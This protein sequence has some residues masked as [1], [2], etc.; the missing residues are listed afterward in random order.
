M[1]LVHI[2]TVQMEKFRACLRGRPSHPVPRGRAMT[3]LVM[4]L[5]NREPNGVVD[6]GRSMCHEASDALTALE[7]ENKRMRAA[8][9][10]YADKS[11]WTR[12][13]LVPK[14]PCQAVYDSGERARAAL[15]GE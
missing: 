1:S 8:L 3:D 15:E 6:H 11:N 13:R 2:V 4:R 5:R 7:E 12:H 10:W 14:M 9:R